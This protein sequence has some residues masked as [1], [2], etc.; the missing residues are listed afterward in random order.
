MSDDKDALQHRASRWNFTPAF[1]VMAFFFTAYAAFLYTS[2]LHQAPGQATYGGE[3]SLANYA[4]YFGSPSDLAVL[5]KTLWISAEL[6]LASLILGYPVAYVIVRTESGAL[7]GLLLGSMAVTFLSG[8]VTRAYA[9]LI[10]LGNNGLINVILKQLG[11][12]SK[13]LQLV[14]NETGVFIALL[15]FVLPFFVLTM[16][17]PLKNVPRSLEESAINLGATRWRAFWHVTLP[18]AVPGIIAAASLTFAMSLSSFLFPLVL[19]GGRVRMVANAIYEYIFS[20]YD[21]PFAAATATIFLVVALFFVWVFS[22]AQ[23]ALT[24]GMKRSA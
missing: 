22:A 11:V 24:P 6:T 16:M 2:L 14:Y 10:I 1:V 9:W 4:R 19:G 21:F 20:S 8:S 7:R 15:H 18:L 12:I 3:P 13:P 17:G 23:R 5:G